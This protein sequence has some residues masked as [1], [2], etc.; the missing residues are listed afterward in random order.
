MMFFKNF[1][2]LGKQVIIRSYSTE[3]K[4]LAKHIPNN[5]NKL[6]SLINEPSLES[7]LKKTYPYF[8]NKEIP[9]ESVSFQ[10]AKYQLDKMANKNKKLDCYFGN[11]F[12]PTYPSETLKQNF[13]TNPNFYSAYIPYQSEISQ[14][15]LE[16]LFN[17]QTMIA[18]LTNMD[19]ANCSLLD[20]SSACA[21]AIVSM[22]NSLSK[23]EKKEVKPILIDENCYEQHIDVVKTRLNN[24][25]IPYKLKN[26]ETIKN[27][28]DYSIVLFQHRTKNGN[29]IN[30]KNT[31][32]LFNKQKTVV[33]FD[34]YASMIYEPP[35]SYGA[36]CVVGST[37]RLGLPMWNGGPHA[38]FL[39]TN[40]PYV[41][42]MPGRIVGKSVDAINDSCYR[43]ALQS[44]EQHIK[45]DKALSNICTSQALLANYSLLYAMFLGREQLKENALYIHRITLLCKQILYENLQNK[46]QSKLYIFN[47]YECFDTLQLSIP[48]LPYYTMV[49]QI[50]LDENL[51][52]KFDKKEQTVT[53]SFDET[54]TL[55][56]LQKLLRTIFYIETDLEEMTERFNN[57]EPEIHDKRRKPLLPHSL[58]NDYTSEHKIVRYLQKLQKKDISLTHSMIPLGSC[59]MKLNS[60]ETLVSLLDDRWGNVHPFTPLSY[61]QG[62]VELINKMKHYLCSITGLPHVSFQSNSGAT[63]EYS[64]LCAIKSY[65]TEQKEKR[66]IVLIPDSAHGTNFASASLAGFTCIK[67]KSTKEGAIDIHHLDEM[68]EKYNKNIACFMVTFPSTFGFFETN[69]KE[70]LDKVKATG[71][72]I[73]C[74]GANMNAFMGLVSLD[75]L[76]VDACHMNLH[77]TFTIPHGGGGPGLGPI[78]VTE[79][80]APHLPNH[81]FVDLEHNKSFGSISSAP[82]SSAV[83]LTIPY[84]YISMCGGEGL[85]QC[86][87]SALLHA[88]YMKQKLEPYYK[89][90]FQNKNN[91]VSHEFIIKIQND[92]SI[93][94][95]DVSK[96]LMDYGYHAPTMSWPVA[97]SL[98]IEPTESENLEEI[99]NFVNSMICIQ[100]EIDDVKNYKN[101]I[102]KNAP[103][104]E[105][106]LYN[107]WKQNYTKAQAFHPLPFV[108]RNKYNIPVSRV[109]DAHGD[110]NLI[111]ID[112]ENKI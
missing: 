37:Q 83:L 25:N 76:G 86:S 85:R 109:D 105:K 29:I 45:K 61:Q 11:G 112:E 104:S 53:F 39:A 33:V 100:K 34:S 38:A 54:K 50:A 9:I 69:I 72:K 20:E 27:P 96:R 59:T 19:M 103:H 74:D 66:N 68:L 106:M 1:F 84:M 81:S 80:L 6:L 75:I 40:K 73:Y 35:G 107:D 88:N 108:K 43:L 16:L 22:F 3:N 101:N 70:I 24:L 44:R 15:R 49:Q 60:S 91:M 12:F 62:Y 47:D 10:D 90:P 48:S 28:N 99:D 42:V 26:V 56:D 18:N 58:F 13:L 97:S 14:G 31:L 32:D 102:L 64:A 71:S 52:L 87:I 55:Q 110:R 30:L 98:M 94:D 51:F 5:F 111:I 63:G 17:Y 89:I 21:E 8:K 65:F 46:L 77:K 93:T 82:F 92:K 78:C 7:F 95:K 67:I 4:Y 23:K 41:R 2:S 79:E 36:S 57:L